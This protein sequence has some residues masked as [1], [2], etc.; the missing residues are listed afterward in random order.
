MSKRIIILSPSTQDTKKWMVKVDGKTVHFGAKGY[1]DFTMH[2]DTERRE[3]YVNRHQA[4][5][6]WGKDGIATAGFWSRWLL[7]NKPTIAASIKDIESRFDVKIS[8]K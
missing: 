3:R 5:E 1:E 4:R 7:W 2:K 6:K 8:R